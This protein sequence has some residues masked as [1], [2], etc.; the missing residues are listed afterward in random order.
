[1]GNTLQVIHIILYF[2]MTCSLYTSQYR[3]RLVLV[4]KILSSRKNKSVLRKIRNSC[5][6]LKRLK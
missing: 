6:Q 5:N 4:N 3:S 1:M 2:I